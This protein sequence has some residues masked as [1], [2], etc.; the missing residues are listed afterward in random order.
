MAGLKLPSR[1]RFQPPQSFEGLDFTFNLFFANLDEL[2]NSLDCLNK[3][4]ASPEMADLLEM[5]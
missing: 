1:V 2:I 3:V 4:A 5:G